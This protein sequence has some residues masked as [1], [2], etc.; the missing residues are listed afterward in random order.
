MTNQLDAND[1][2]SAFARATAAGRAVIEG[3]RP[4]QYLLPTPCGD[5]AVRDLLNH[6]VMVMRRVAVLGRLG[7]LM[8]VP[9]D[10]VVADGTHGD[11]WVAAA[12]QVQAAW[13]R[14]DALTAMVRVPWA[15]L[16]GAD[17]VAIYTNEIVVH[18]WELAAATGQSVEWD[19]QVLAVSFAAIQ[20]QMP[21][22]G[23][24]EFF[25]AFAAELP[26]PASFEPPF[27]AAVPVP[28][29][30]P[31]IDQLVAWNGRDPRWTPAG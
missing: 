24:V 4:D 19:D 8:D 6:L 22:E 12:H 28:T 14:P 31:A 10:L 27:A 30:A 29:D 23:R 5:Y 17:T 25:E 20:A 18:T 3:V 7:N 26:D 9:D 11:E 2:R 1:P 13:D 15:E 21:A 16:T